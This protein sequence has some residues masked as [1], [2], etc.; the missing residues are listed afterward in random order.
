MES[1]IDGISLKPIWKIVQLR[2]LIHVASFLSEM[3]LKLSLNNQS[4]TSF[5]GGRDWLFKSPRAALKRYKFMHMLQKD[6]TVDVI[7]NVDDG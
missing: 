4:K 1:D 7:V 2:K 3:T 5:Y 6:D